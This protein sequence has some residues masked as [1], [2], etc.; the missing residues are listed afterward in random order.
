MDAINNTSLNTLYSKFSIPNSYKEYGS[1]LNS[2]SN[3]QVQ[4]YN[5]EKK[6]NKKKLKKTLIIGSTLFTL[7]GAI[8]FAI[9][10]KKFKYP[11]KIKQAEIKDFVENFG[12]NINNIKDECVQRTINFIDEKTPLK[13]I[14]KWADKFSNWYRSNVFK[15]TKGKYEKAQQEIKN[16]LGDK[17]LSEELKDFKTMFESLNSNIA[18]TAQ[19]ETLGTKALFK[20]DKGKIK[21]LLYNLSHPLSDAKIAPDVTKYANLIEIPQDA[22]EGLKKAI[23]NYN[24]LQKEEIIPKLRDIAYGA[25]PSDFVTAAIPIGTFGVALAAADDKEERKSLF[26]NLGIPLFPTV[27]MPILGTIFP[28]LNGIKAMVAGFAVGNIFSMAAKFLDKKINGDK[29]IK[30]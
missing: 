3:K 28:V 17:K 1:K 2:Y 16:A 5:D 20:R 26:L 10:N 30:A 8:A 15:A 9:S 18:Q 6:E 22:D 19:K 29:E 25:A 24:K 7:A 14:K 4:Y 13:F 21:N 27:T 23:E 11:T 12:N